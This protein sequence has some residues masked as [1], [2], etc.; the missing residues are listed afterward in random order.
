MDLRRR[1]VGRKK[2]MKRKEGRGEGIEMRVGMRET[3]R[4][5]T[6]E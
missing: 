3:E 5:G 2:T 6:R 4:G 1:G